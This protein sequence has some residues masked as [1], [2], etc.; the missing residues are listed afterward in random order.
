MERAVRYIV[1][2][3]VLAAAALALPGLDCDDPG[4]IHSFDYQVMGTRAQ[5][6]IYVWD[7]T[8]RRSPVQVVQ[9]TFDSVNT[10]LS[11][12]RADSEVGRFNAAAA[13][14]TYAISKWLSTCLRVSEEM[15]KISDGAFDP[16]AGPLMDLWGFRTR[17]GRLPSPAELDSA[18]ALLGGYEHDPFQR[19]LTK[20]RDGTR[21]DL[22][23]IAKGFAVDRAVANLIEFGT[24]SALIDLGG[25]VFAL[26]L[27]DDRD[28]WRVGVR[29]PLDPD[30]LLAS[31]DMVNRAA[32]T[33]G[34]Y[35]RFVEIDG[36][37]YGHVMNPATG[38][39]AE[40]L[41]SVTVICRSATLAD[42]LSTTLFVVGPE[43]ARALLHDHYP[44]V[45]AVLVLPA[46]ESAGARVI[47]TAGLKNTLLLTPESAGRYV[48]EFMD[49]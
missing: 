26:G 30:A 45:D 23:G 13:G 10:R 8:V 43:R 44:H 3:A 42:A 22:G 19:K 14:S 7:R 17:A 41:L 37:R 5:G 48:L 27:P 16:S 29:D 18:R 9:A 34:A 39:P 20:T 36:R 28:A 6:E 12:W 11:S 15:Q 47:A 35:E 32:A 49:F 25:N 4:D 38:H 33:S 40:G 46:D 24:S 1:V 31:F 21:L 2:I